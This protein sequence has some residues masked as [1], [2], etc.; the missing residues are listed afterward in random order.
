[1]YILAGIG[2]GMVLEN[3]AHSSCILLQPVTVSKIGQNSTSDTIPKN[4]TV[5]PLFTCLF[6]EGIKISPV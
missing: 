6:T 4:N 1:M 2:T 3:Y 5:E